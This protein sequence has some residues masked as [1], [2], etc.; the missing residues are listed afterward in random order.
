M[1]SGP[2]KTARKTLGIRCITV[3]LVMLVV[4]CSRADSQRAD[5]R[6]PIDTL[7]RLAGPSSPAFAD[8]AG[9][10]VI[11]LTAF[12]R[13]TG[14]VEFGGP[15]PVD[16]EVHVTTDADL[17][18]E[19]LIDITV[20]NRGPRLANAIVWLEGVTA[21]KRLPLARRYD[22]T[23]EGCR[24][25]PHVQAAAI[26]GTLDVRNADPGAHLARFTS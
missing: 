15:A 12:G 2:A 25:I 4:A 11:P 20:E 18:G 26:G 19:T 21:G 5:T 1:K 8:S 14:T 3:V 23:S 9:Y 17:C 16:S 13:V 22:I 10:R 7:A 6:A 24:F